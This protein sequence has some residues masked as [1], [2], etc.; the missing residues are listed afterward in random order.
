MH[1]SSNGQDAAL[2]RRKRGVRFSLGVPFVQCYQGIA[3]GR[4][5]YAGPTGRERVLIKLH[6]LWRGS[7][8]LLNLHDNTK[9]M[10]MRLQLNGQSSGLIIHWLGVQVPSG[11]PTWGYNLVVKYPAFNRKTRVQFSVPLPYKFG[12]LDAKACASPDCKSGPPW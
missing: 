1:L 9:Q 7:T 10:V 12:G 11:A 2:S 5:C 6:R 8:S 4:I 3:Y